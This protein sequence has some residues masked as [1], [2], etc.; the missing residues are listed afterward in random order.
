[1][2]VIDLTALDPH[3]R[4][5]IIARK[6]DAQIIAGIAHHVGAPVTVYIVD[7]LDADLVVKVAGITVARIPD[8]DLDGLYGE[9]GRVA[10]IARQARAGWHAYT[11]PADPPNIVRGTE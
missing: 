6:R 10:H 9:L 3:E 1:M 7:G 2:A 4:A 11:P 5:R 8:D